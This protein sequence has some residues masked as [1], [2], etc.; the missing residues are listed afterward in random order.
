MS[1][2][3][4]FEFNNHSLWTHY[5]PKPLSA[6]LNTPGQ[7]EVTIP[8]LNPATDILFPEGATGVELWLYVYAT[9][10]ENNAPT[11]EYHYKI[12]LLVN[13]ASVAATVWTAQVVPE[14]YFVLVTAKLLYF[15]S[16]RFN[17]RNY[18][19]HKMLNPAKVLLGSKTGE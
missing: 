10:F 18:L 3:N 9:N 12:T 19:N 17:T 4:D 16:N 1:G 5:C 6:V 2:L 15:E 11:V 8:N 13:E 14:H 7:V